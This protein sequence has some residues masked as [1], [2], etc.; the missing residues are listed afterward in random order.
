MKIA[1]LELRAFG[2]FTG[3][4]LDLDAGSHGLHLIYGPNEAGK[5]STLRALKQFLYGIPNRSADNFI[6]SYADLRI[7]AALRNGDGQLLECIRRK[8]TKNDLREADDSTALDPER[9]SR[10]LA[11]LDREAFE[12]MFGIDHPTLVKGG[13]EIV[14][15]GGSLG[16]ILFAAGS[17]IAELRAVQ[18]NLDDAAA[19]LFVPRG[20]VPKINKNLSE[21]DKARKAVKE[22]QLPSSEWEKHDKALRQARERLGE[23]EQQLQLV[24]HERRRLERQRDALPL[25]ARREAVCGRLAELG[26]VQLLSDDFADKRRAAVGK[27]TSAEA[28]ARE[29]EAALGELDLQLEALAPPEHLIAQNEAIERLQN[30]LGGYRKAQRDLPGLQAAKSAREADAVAILAEL[31]P[32]V[33]LAEVESLRLTRRQQASIQNLGNRSAAV[34]ERS[35]QTRDQFEARSRRLKAADEEQQSLAA[36]RD[37]GPLTALLRRVRGLAHLE[38][39]RA[40]ARAALADL[41]EQA[42]TAL[43]RLGLW[44]GALEE[45]KKL[46]APTAETIDRH[47]SELADVAGRLKTA[48][49]QIAAAEANLAALDQRIE[50]LQLA[51]DV[52]SETELGAARA[53][54]ETGWR[55]VREAWLGGNSNAQAEADFAASSGGDDLA[56]A[57]EQ[58]VRQ[59]D[60]VSDR[61][62]READR[63]AQRA[64]LA[65]SRAAAAAELEKLLA[66]RERAAAEKSR[67]E[68][69]WA[70]LWLP[71]TAAPLPPREMRSWDARRLVLVQKSEA[72]RK[73]QSDLAA[74]DERIERC[75]SELSQALAALGEPP[76]AES[77]S[78]AALV[79]RSQNV[80]DR[81]AA[82]A[83]AREQLAKEIAA[84]ARDLDD[85]RRQAAEAERELAAWRL[86]WLS[87]VE[88]LGLPA[89]ATPAQA[90]E[91]VAQ[92][93]QL[94]DKLKDAAGFGERIDGIGREGR[95]F[96]DE[97]GSLVAALAPE[98]QSLSPEEAA[99]KLIARRQQALAD[100]G[101]SETIQKERQRHA[102]QLERAKQ[103]AGEARGLLAALCQEA[104]AASPEELPDLE[105]ASADLRELERELHRLDEQ[106]LALAGGAPLDEFLP[107]LAALDADGVPG[108]LERLAG[109]IEQLESQRAESNRT[110]GAETAEL[111]RMDASGAA[112]DAADRAQSL[113]AELNADVEQYARLRLAAAV[114]RESIERYR[115]RNQGPVLARASALFAQLTVGSFAELRADYNDAGEAVLVGIRAA[116][117]KPVAVECMSDGTADQLYLA[118][119][120]ASLETWLDDK[121]PIP[122]IVDDILIRFDNAR[123]AAT[124]SALAALSRRT[125]V[126]FFTHHEH[127]LDLA[128]QTLKAGEFFVHGLG[129]GR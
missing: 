108:R 116:D 50:Q 6:H 72:I 63:V 26:Q 75:R 80:A 8:A 123:S 107:E 23:L 43:A 30:D 18:K 83:A 70:E 90:N 79:E 11:G 59:A 109:Q 96:V 125:Q 39:D 7:A 35:K 105:R 21:F 78:L 86:E 1:R 74:L 55:L 15:G 5:T 45:L 60:D 22:A 17:G 111:A 106:L 48:A 27:L 76:A 103:S 81:S 66:E 120:L 40:A 89:D 62:R 104:R 127:L 99:H 47:E 102:A 49:R 84:L 129:C 32:G 57:Y 64:E 69:A 68:A 124:L 51:G 44:Q 25:A 10:L 14:A 13:Q 73:Q 92:L 42:E 65:A 101:R 95:Q 128:E 67:A 88:P 20:S 33:S 24:Q 56:G 114:L 34:A 29:A 28:Q 2:P 118:L 77:E 52:P 37:A 94:F 41:Q 9:L 115:A 85:D 93:Q 91:V 61:L 19:A 46:P 97:V 117:G 31:R 3:L 126:L 53:R 119:R 36:P 58:S 110:I 100:R 12:T 38:D 121:E 16:Q 112:A 71:F 113:L 122:F 87:A 4:A 98:W 54:R 82:A